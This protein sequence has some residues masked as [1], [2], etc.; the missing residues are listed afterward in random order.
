MGEE[1][2]KKGTPLQI[3]AKAD[4]PG[5]VFEKFLKALDSSDVSPEVIARLRKT[6]LDDQTFTD[7]A[8]KVAVLG[9]EET[10]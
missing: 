9:E 4:I 10:L 1:D 3:E 5:Q 6:L 7:S 8:L 2:T